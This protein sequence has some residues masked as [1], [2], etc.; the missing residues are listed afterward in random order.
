MKRCRRLPTRSGWFGWGLALIA[1]LI[2]NVAAIPAKAEQIR[3][4]A[5]GDSLTAGYQLPPTAAFP[6]KL[7]AALMARGHD[8]VVENAG[9]SGDTS[10][11]GLSRLDW[12]VGDGVDGVILE[13]GANDALR[14][15]QPEF[16]EKALS[17]IVARLKEREIAV[18]VAGMLAPPNMGAD[19]GDRFNGIFP[20]LA[21]RYDTLLYPFFLDGVA[22]DPT[23]NLDDGIHPNEAGI[24]IIVARMLPYVEQ[25]IERIE[26]ARAAG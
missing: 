25:L 9:V 6:V 21:T 22:A 8:V 26:A 14:G 15:I 20:R 1:L 11:G 23:L 16:T 4:V 12:S 24:D 2:A 10:T 19:Y 13:L 18:L 5:F 17:D 3:L 7:E